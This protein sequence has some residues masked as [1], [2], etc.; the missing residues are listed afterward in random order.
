MY[1]AD[2]P[3]KTPSGTI[4][5][6]SA[7]YLAIFGYEQCQEQ[8]FCLPCL[9]ILRERSAETDSASRLPLNGGIVRTS[10][11]LFLSLL[12]LTNCSIFNTWIVYTMCHHIH[13][14]YTEASFYPYHIH[15]TYDSYSDL[16]LLCY[17]RCLSSFL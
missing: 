17:K 5:C 16:C 15:R 13:G 1:A 6:T 14:T 4:H 8:Q 12:D 11:Y 2:E 10:V 3:N 9:C 7:A